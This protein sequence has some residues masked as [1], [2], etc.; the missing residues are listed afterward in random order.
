MNYNYVCLK[1][2]DDSEIKKQ[3]LSYL[4]NIDNCLNILK[5]DLDKYLGVKKLVGIDKDSLDLYVKEENKDKLKGISKNKIMF[6]HN[7]EYIGL[8]P[9]LKNSLIYKEY[10][11]ILDKHK[12]IVEKSKKPKITLINCSDKKIFRF[13]NTDVYI[14]VMNKKFVNTDNNFEKYSIKKYINKELSNG[15]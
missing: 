15:A 9:V 3:Y 8:Y 11:K 2:K 14:L 1:L 4:N 10:I 6:N 7:R 13:I 5:K 12:N